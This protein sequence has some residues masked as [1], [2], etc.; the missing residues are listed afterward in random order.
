MI[1]NIIF[2]FGD[3]FL[4]LDKQSLFRQIDPALIVQ[5]FDQFDALNK[6]YEVGHISTDTFIDRVLEL[7][8]ELDRNKVERYWNGILLDFPESRLD[9]LED[10]AKTGKYRLFLLSNTNA[11]HFDFLPGHMGQDRFNRFKSGFEGFYLSHEIGLRKPG[12]EVFR[13]VLDT[14]GLDPGETLFIDDSI[15]NIKG[16]DALGIATWHLLVGKDDVL[17][18]DARLTP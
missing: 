15:E 17:D 18:L 3:V 2:D 12:A 7:L 5:K 13:F 4:N 1:K 11:M 6:E 9:F 14:N 16:A 8:P 10:L